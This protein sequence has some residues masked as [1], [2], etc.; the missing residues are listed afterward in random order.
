MKSIVKKYAGYIAALA[1][2][3]CALCVAFVDFS[4]AEKGAA[5]EEFV[6]T[7]QLT[8]LTETGYTVENNGK[9]V[10]VSVNKSAADGG[11]VTLGPAA[12]R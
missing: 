1:L 12:Q 10:D 2:I 6:N 11:A 5:A 8:Y 3:V 9:K 4:A 7:A